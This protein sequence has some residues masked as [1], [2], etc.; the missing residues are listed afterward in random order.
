MIF[1]VF[2]LVDLC[3]FEND[4]LCTWQNSNEV[5]LQWLLNSGPTPSEDTGPSYDHTYQFDANVTGY[6]D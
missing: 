3:D 4:D 2:S 1:S 5:E 6:S